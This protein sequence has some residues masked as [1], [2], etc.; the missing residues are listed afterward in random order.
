LQKVNNPVTNWVV[1]SKKILISVYSTIAKTATSI[2]EN[3]SNLADKSQGLDLGNRFIPLGEEKVSG[4]IYPTGFVGACFR[5]GQKK[6]KPDVVLPRTA[7]NGDAFDFH[8][9]NHELEVLLRKHSNLMWN[10]ELFS[11][12]RN[13]EINLL[14]Y[15]ELKFL[16][17]SSIQRCRISSKLKNREGLKGIGSKARRMVESAAKYLQD[18]CQRRNLAFLT[19]T[20]PNMQ[21]KHLELVA[22]NF[23]QVVRVFFEE[24]KRLYERRGEEFEYVG[25]VELQEER[26]K[27]YRHPGLHIHAVF[28]GRSSIKKPWVVNKKEYSLLWERAIR[29]VVPQIPLST[30]FGA[31]TRIEV[32]RKS[33]SGYL[34]KY[35]SKG[36]Q[37]VSEMLNEGFSNCIPHRW[38]SISKSLKKKVEETIIRGQSPEIAQVYQWIRFG[39]SE[40]YYKY[41][42]VREDRED[43]N[44]RVLGFWCQL[45][46]KG[47]SAISAMKL[48]SAT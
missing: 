10:G 20:I 18:K 34:A 15:A 45:N 16:G 12:G 8:L 7:P 5:W 23:N 41:G 47:M 46:S 42:Y 21:T 43:E 31:S 22:A 26:W 11:L 35:L 4:S 14:D 27:K 19:C 44:S 1:L 13:K 38:W 25:V 36:V 30:G 32:V 33:A 28:A 39:S 9:T 6:E 24:L 48:M 17:L 40:Y 2:A 37:I 29:R 3:S